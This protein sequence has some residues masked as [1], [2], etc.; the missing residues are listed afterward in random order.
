MGKT[1]GKR[2]WALVQVGFSINIAVLDKALTVHF[3]MIPHLTFFLV[4]IQTNLWDNLW[5]ALTFGQSDLN[6]SVKD[7]PQPDRADGCP[8]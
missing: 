5:P 7:S 1:R 6:E 2:K 8:P 3:K 4:S